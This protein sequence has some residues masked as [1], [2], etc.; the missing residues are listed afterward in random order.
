MDDAVFKAIE[1]TGN[2]EKIEFARKEIAIARLNAEKNKGM[3]RKLLH[4]QA[5]EWERRLNKAIEDQ[6]K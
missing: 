3:V 5:N 4:T 1:R 2:P 6:G